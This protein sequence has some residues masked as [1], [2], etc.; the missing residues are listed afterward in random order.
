M[1]QL[2]DIEGGND[3][4]AKP[5][6]G[7]S[8]LVSSA[9]RQEGAPDSPP[10]LPHLVIRPPNLVPAKGSAVDQMLETV[11]EQVKRS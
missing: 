10:L 8:Y 5:S 4:Q 6:A 1:L 9:S 2:R 7:V 11:I 3:L